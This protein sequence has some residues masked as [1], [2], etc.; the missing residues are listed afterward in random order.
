MKDK[1]KFHE[2]ALGRFDAAYTPQ[3][4][5]RESIR[6]AIRFARKN[7]AQW[8]G[9]T[10]AGWA[11]GDTMKGRPLMEANRISNSVERITG[12]GKNSRISVKFRPGD[13]DASVKLAES[14]NGK[15][16]ADFNNC[17]GEEASD[18]AYEDAVS[19][20]FGCIRLSTAPDNDDEDPSNQQRKR[21][22]M[23][24]VPEAYSTVWFD[25]AAKK[26]DKSDGGYA[27]ELFSISPAEY[28]RKY[29]KDPA[30][31][32]KPDSI[33]FDWFRDDA[34]YIGRYYERRLET[35]TI[36]T[37]QNALTGHTVNYSENQ[38][39]PL[40]DELARLGYFQL[41]Q[42][43]RKLYQVY[44]SVID[45][46]AII[47]EPVRLPGTMIPLVP[48]YG[49]RFYNEGKEQVEGFTQKAMDPQIAFNVAFSMMTKEAA[50]ATPAQTVINEKF[51]RGFEH[52]WNNRADK[53][54]LP[55]HDGAAG[56]QT[57][58]KDAPPPYFQTSA[59]SVSPSVMNL[60]SAADQIL[61]QLTG[62]AVS[63]QQVPGNVSGQ[64]VNAM[65][66]RT[67]QQDYNFIDNLKKSTRHLGRV[68]L[69][70]SREVYGSTRVVRIVKPNGEDELVTLSEQVMDND[71]G[72]VIG[73]NDL[74]QGKYDVT[75]SIGP[76]FAT[77]RQQSIENLTTIMKELPVNPE[78]QSELAM[79]IIDMAAGEGLDDLKKVVH[80]QLLLSGAVEPKTPQEARQV[81]EAQQQQAQAAQNNP[82]NIIAQ[83]QATKARA[84]MFNSVAKMIDSGVNIFATEADTQLKASE[85]LKNLSD[86]DVSRTSAM[87]GILTAFTKQEETLIKSQLS[88]LGGLNG[89][90]SSSDNN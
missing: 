73:I 23:E 83:S 68:W 89:H 15:F 31:I 35:V 69:S 66:G 29:K 28:K 70:M 52:I 46:E 77:A 12:E 60:F 90:D 18:T 51:I 67:D 42:E 71:T 21:I 25:P 61:T 9:K 39:E 64:A 80:R 30:T 75:V 82:T 22:V 81:Q 72:D 13:S 16:R 88:Y 43:P 54:Y 26:Y 19:G 55:I 17:E 32:E 24:Y 6:V 3:T 59:S 85:M 38:I 7:G 2:T 63:E 14:L 74:T 50:E 48:Y 49:K 27:F 57:T 65:T 76:A 34:V 8:E 79:Y 36:L 4:G 1:K 44:C 40:R 10:A 78:V 47:E 5:I 33:T 37:Y 41:S 45:G 53:A 62:N 87:T 20:G 11:H 84:D 58:V 86:I 56:P